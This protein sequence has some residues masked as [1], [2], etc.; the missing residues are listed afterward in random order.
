MTA[1]PPDLI[2]TAP[3]GVAWRRLSGGTSTGA[4]FLAALAIWA[5]PGGR[6]AREWNWWQDGRR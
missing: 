5:D 2:V 1:A 6:I 3:N 4:Q